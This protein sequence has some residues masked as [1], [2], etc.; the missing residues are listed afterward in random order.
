MD[1]S[2]RRDISPKSARTVEIIISNPYCGFGGEP[3][4]SRDGESLEGGETRLATGTIFTDKL[5]TSQREMAGLGI[6]HYGARFYSPK[7]GRFLSPDTLV[8][9]FANPQSW[10]RYSYVLNN[11]ILYT[12]PTGHFEVTGNDSE[13]GC[14]TASC[15]IDMYSGYGDYEGM[16][17][18]LQHYVDRHPDYNPATDPELSDEDRYIVSNAM[19]QVAVQDGSPE[20]IL[21]TAG[22][23]S[24][25]AI[26]IDG[27]N[28]SP[29]DGFSGG[30]DSRLSPSQ[31]PVWKNLDSYQG[32]IR[33]SGSGRDSRY[34]EWDF[35]HGDIEVYDRNGNHLGSMDPITGQ[36]Y[37][38]PVKGRTIEVK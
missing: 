33:R 38:P 23:V 2:S 8:P 31:S 7:L 35:T 19:F 1:H 3:I 30:G 34:Y 4:E 22:L 32:K 9:N 25:F 15:I 16:D 26:I 10:N 37:K 11:P 18:S 13:A 17:D 27:I 6:Y 24:F 5:F 28:M 36:L 20:E 21:T 29:D 12:D 14:N